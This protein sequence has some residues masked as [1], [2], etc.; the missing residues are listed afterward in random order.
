[1]ETTSILKTIHWLGHAGVKI[2]G[3]KTITID[4]YEINDTEQAD[5]ILITHDHYD[6]LSTEDI[7]KIS[8]EKTTFVVP[9]IS[10]GKLHGT[11][12]TVNPGD[13]LVIE[14]IE[15]EAVPAY[16][17]GKQ[18]H[19]QANHYC[20]YVFKMNQI[21][22]Y[23]AGDTDAIPEMKHVQADV[24]FLPVGGTY[25]MTAE[26]A[27]GVVQDIQPQIAIPIHW[28]NIIGS[29]KDAEKFKQLC[30]NRAVILKPES[31]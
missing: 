28:G 1:M 16:N 14:G 22:Y 26:E 4:P 24:V 12:R 2:S 17:I 11:V 8:G 25:T 3:E 18:F 15:I 10:A 6:H 23:H 5:I 31:E 29:R 21:T 13:R 19:P 30:G 7:Q 9:S 27:A 20:G